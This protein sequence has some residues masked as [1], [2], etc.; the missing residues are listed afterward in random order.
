VI[1]R[2]SLNSITVMVLSQ[3]MTLKKSKSSK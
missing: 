1:K 3:T 2:L